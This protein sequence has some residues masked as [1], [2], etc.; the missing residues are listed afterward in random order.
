MEMKNRMENP[1][2]VPLTGE[3]NVSETAHE[4]PSIGK[5]L[6]RYFR[7]Y[8]EGSSLIGFRYLGEKR[9]RGERILW[10]LIILLSIVLSIYYVVEIY[11]KYI[12]NPFIV[13]LAT[14]ESHIFTIPFPAVTIC[15]TV[16][17]VKK[18][19]NFTGAIHRLYDNKNITD[20][21]MRYTQYFSLLCNTLDD[22][23]MDLLPPNKTFTDDFFDS[24]DYLNPSFSDVFAVCRF[25]GKDEDCRDLFVPIVVDEGICYTFNMLNKEDIYKDDVYYYSDYLQ[26][27]DHTNWTINDGYPKG[28]GQNVYPRRALLSGADNA[29]EIYL[30]QGTL[31]T[32]YLCLQDTKGFS[33]LLHSPHTIPQLKKNFFSVPLDTAV[34]AIVKPGMMTTSKE[35]KNYKTKDRKCYFTDERFLK[36]F[37][38]YTPENCQLECL[39]NQ[40][41]EMC[42]CVNYFMPRHNTTNICGNVMTDCM[43]KAEFLMKTREIESQL[44]EDYPTPNSCNCMPIC[45]SL[46]YQSETSR[47]P[48]PWKNIFR[49]EKNMAKFLAPL[50]I[51]KRMHFSR[52]NIYFGSDVFLQMERTELYGFFD[53]MSNIGGILGLFNG[54]ALLSIVEIVYYISVRLWC[55]YQLHNDIL[56][57]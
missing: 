20:E 32:D 21:D 47:T 33:V 44:S 13:N 19:F 36:Y 28:T 35:V 43:E 10:F 34:Q 52:L 3:R 16:K 1:S 54:F 41:L 12:E 57:S 6:R 49:A 53:L 8:C 46:S 17:T 27:M 2:A 51:E 11:N 23:Y 14:R 7:D 38:I 26:N 15:P 31:E 25:M 50:E 30:L 29:L 55:N 18:Y 5:K 39:T 56:E 45:T 37:E 40:T 22:S 9:S 42:N 24:L 48:F 4:N